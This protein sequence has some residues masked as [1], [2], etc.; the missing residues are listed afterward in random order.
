[1]NRPRQRRGILVA[2]TAVVV[3]VGLLVSGWFA[4]GAFQSPEQVAAAASPPPP[5]RVTGEVTRGDLR[6]QINMESTVT[7]KRTEDVPL[8]PAEGPIVVTKAPIA[9]GSAVAAGALIFE[10]NG[11]PVF[12]L[13]GSFPL[14]RDLAQGDSGTDVRQLQAGLR[15]AGFSVTVDGVIGPSTR[16]AIE[17][18]YRDAGYEA[19]SAGVTTSRPPTP[20][21]NT[22]DATNDQ[23]APEE[24]AQITVAKASAFVVFASAPAFLIA[25]PP[26]GAVADGATLSLAS[27]AP[28][29][30]ATVTTSTAASL[31]LEM[32]AA[33]QLPNGSTVDLVI[34][35][36]GKP[37]EDGSV[38]VTLRSTTSPIPNKFLGTSLVVSVTRQLV[39][40]GAL[41]VPTR[42][43]S[44]RGGDDQIVLRSNGDGSFAEVRV[45]EIAALGGRSAIEQMDKGVRLEPGDDVMVQ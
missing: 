23:A 14:Y 36:I 9:I 38:S 42:A 1:M 43:I 4:A 28:Q 6:D 7:R 26:V 45:R 37:T 3:G 21:T 13:P 32:P 44:S 33:A 8:P 5:S 20:T 34:S 24:T 31:S 25:A 11:E 2:G 15:E 17:K 16:S 29:A 41:I 10:I 35:S 40:E 27:G 12:A 30:I 22:D 18:L 39:A 19:P